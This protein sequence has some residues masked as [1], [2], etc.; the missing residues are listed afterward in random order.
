M[1]ERRLLLVTE[2]QAVDKSCGLVR[3][4]ILPCLD[5]TRQLVGHPITS[6]GSGMHNNKLIYIIY[7]VSERLVKIG[8]ITTLCFRSNRSLLLSRL[9]H[10]T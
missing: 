5:S 6:S 9:P 8:Q 10:S 4:R 2:R 1:S 7:T 3:V